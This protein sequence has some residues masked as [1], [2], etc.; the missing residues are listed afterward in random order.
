MHCSVRSSSLATV[1]YS[2]K[3]LIA[4]F[5]FP[6]DVQHP[7][8]AVLH[9]QNGN[10]A[11]LLCYSIVQEN[12]NFNFIVLSLMYHA[13]ILAFNLPGTN[14]S[15]KKPRGENGEPYRTGPD[16]L[17]PRAFELRPNRALLVLDIFKRVI[18]EKI[19]ALRL[20]TSAT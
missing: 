9:P 10:F 16:Q 12:A 17:Y 18:D 13:L 20:R 15:I 7:I 6:S 3:N 14:F 1:P 8:T 5:H 2:T 4:C 19:F 11:R